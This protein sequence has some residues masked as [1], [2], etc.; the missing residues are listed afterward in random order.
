MSQCISPQY[1]LI[2]RSQ[3]TDSA[4]FTEKT[5][6]DQA[7]KVFIVTGSSSGVRKELAQIPYSHNAKVYVAAR[8]SKKASKA[9]ESIKSSIELQLGANDIAPFLFT[10]LLTPILVTT[11][12]SS[13]PGSV[14]VVWVSSGAA[15]ESS[16]PGGHK[17]ITSKV[18]NILL[19]K[20][21][22]KRCGAGGILSLAATCSTWQNYIHQKILYIPIHNAYTGLFAS[23]SPGVTPETNGAWTKLFHL[24]ITQGRFA[25]P[26]KDLEA[27]AKSEEEGGTGTGK[28]LEWTEA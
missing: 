17:Y 12:K 10:K 25:P 15:E 23:L 11:A 19:T 14:R 8:C 16:P 7:S 9:I 26:R 28:F 2:T 21:Y 24:I 13:S 27:S 20:E 3:L 22:A 18:N 6:P 1:H 5:I 4:R